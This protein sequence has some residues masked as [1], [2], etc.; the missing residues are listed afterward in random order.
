MLI[1]SAF[2]LQ[3]DKESYLDTLIEL[4]AMRDRME[5]Y[6]IVDNIRYLAR[7]AAG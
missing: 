3:R 6:F 2:D 4:N 5:Q 7:R 1:K